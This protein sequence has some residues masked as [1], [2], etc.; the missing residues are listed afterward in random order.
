[1]TDKTPEQVAR[2]YEL[3]DFLKEHPDEHDQASWIG[4]WG[5][6]F[7]LKTP[8][9]AARA[10]NERG[11]TA[12][13]AGWTCLLAGDEFV[14]IERVAFPGGTALVPARACSL[15]GLDAD[16]AQALFYVADDLSDVADLI[17]EFFGPHPDGR[18]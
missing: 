15:L 16:E 3:L 11:T 12:C 13:V 14:D 2:A 10:L 5:D 17:A 1:M 8:V 6:A 7:A 18:R 4:Y 9:N